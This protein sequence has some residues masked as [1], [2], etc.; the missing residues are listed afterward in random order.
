MLQLIDLLADI[1]NL[2]N[3]EENAKITIIFLTE[4]P[5]KSGNW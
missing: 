5:L 2:A 3:P 1:L 4:T